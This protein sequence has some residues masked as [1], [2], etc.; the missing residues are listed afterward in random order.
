[1][2][3][4]ARFSRKPIRRYAVV[5][6]VVA[7]PLLVNYANILH[8]DAA[9]HESALADGVASAAPDHALLMSSDVERALP[10]APR[11]PP[12]A[13]GPTTL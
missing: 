10:V 4:L 1:M 7:A 6:A 13:L 9:T 3:H 12:E 2:R 5:L 8:D 11:V